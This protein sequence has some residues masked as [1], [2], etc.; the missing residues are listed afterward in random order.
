MATGI[1]VEAFEPHDAEAV[2]E[3]RRATVPYL[4]CTAGSVA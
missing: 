2:A 3:V 4:V 1:T